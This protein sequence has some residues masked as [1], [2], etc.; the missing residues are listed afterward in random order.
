MF[1]L[2]LL[3]LSGVAAAVSCSSGSTSTTPPATTTSSPGTAAVA[4]QNFA[5]S[6]ATLTVTVGTKV[7][8][9]NKDSATHTV[10]SLQGN[11]LNSGNI[12]SGGTFS[13]TFSQKGTFDYQ[14]AI[15]T[16]MT[17]KVIVQ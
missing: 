1:M 13:F 9:T 3:A 8:W 7:T 15:H 12:A 2:A 10:T 4:I 14:C 17:G 11:V 5:F 16:S 6:P